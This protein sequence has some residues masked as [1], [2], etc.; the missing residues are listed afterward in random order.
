MAASVKVKLNRAAVRELLR[1]SEVEADLLRRAQAIAATA[2]G[3][4]SDPGGHH[5]DSVIGRNRARAAV[6][7][8]TAKAREAE[9]K[10]RALTRSLDA[11]RS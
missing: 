10:D 1:S 8:V 11:G 7:T 3:I 5:A 2:D 9:A 6:A 4:A